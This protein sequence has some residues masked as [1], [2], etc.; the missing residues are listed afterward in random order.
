MWAPFLTSFHILEK[1]VSSPKLWNNTI[2]S[3]GKKQTKNNNN[4][5]MNNSKLS[6]KEMFVS[7]FNYFQ[8]VELIARSPKPREKNTNGSTFCIN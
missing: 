8:Y 7:L 3:T 4:N 5:I 1:I 6:F 2:W